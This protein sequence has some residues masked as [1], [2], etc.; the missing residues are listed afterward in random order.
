MLKRFEKYYIE[1]AKGC[2]R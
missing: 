2:E 1:V